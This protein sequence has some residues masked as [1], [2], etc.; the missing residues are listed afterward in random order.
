[1]GWERLVQVQHSHPQTFQIYCIAPGRQKLSVLL[2]LVEIALLI[3][4]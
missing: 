4:M 3:E 2:E 1:M